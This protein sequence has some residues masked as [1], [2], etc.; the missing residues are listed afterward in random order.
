MSENASLEP[1]RTEPIVGFQVKKLNDVQP[2][3]LAIRFAFG[4]AVSVLASVCGVVFSPI[5]GGMFLAFPA[6]LPASLT[7]LQQKEGTKAAVED[8]G[9]A[10]L[11]SVGLVAFAVLAAVLFALTPD[12]LVFTAA[13]AGWLILS[14]GLYLITAVWRRRR[15]SDG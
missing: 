6:I 14:I 1:E 15:E 12:V 10:V 11:G 7:L 2:A 5:M 13:T 8:V 3:N 9:G 4:A